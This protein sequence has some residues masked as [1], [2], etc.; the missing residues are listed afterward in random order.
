MIIPDQ[1]KGKSLLNF[2]KNKKSNFI[3]VNKLDKYQK[4]V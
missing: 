4:Q 2:L 1:N 3:D